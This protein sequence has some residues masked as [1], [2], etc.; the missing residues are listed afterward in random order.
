MRSLPRGGGKGTASSWSSG[1][2]SR[3]EGASGEGDGGELLE[4]EDGV[5]SVMVSSELSGPGAHA[6]SRTH[7]SSAPRS[8]TMKREDWGEGSS[9]VDAAEEQMEPASEEAASS[10][11][12]SAA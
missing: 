7:V 3:G 4:T 5:P 11:W 6:E 12:R 10:S 9:C 2:I 1:A 8:C